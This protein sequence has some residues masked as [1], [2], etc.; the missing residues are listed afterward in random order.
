MAVQQ[1]NVI[2]RFISALLPAI[3]GVAIVLAVFEGYLVYQFTHPK[4]TGEEVTP[5]HYEVL[6][7]GSLPWSQ[8]EWSNLDNTKAVG[9]FLRG[10]SGAPAIV[11]N[12]AYGK[13]RSELLNLGVKLREAGY[14]VLLPDLR[15]HGA[16]PVNW[17]S[18]GEYER[19]DLLA[20]IKFL[21]A[22]R[23]NQGHPLVDGDRIGVYG[24]SLGGYIAV[25]AAA[26]EPSI[27][28]V[29]A[30]SIYPESKALTQ[31]LVD[32]LFTAKPPALNGLVNLGMRCYFLGHYGKASVPEALGS[33]QGRKLWLVT[34]GAAGAFEQSTLELFKQAPDPKEMSLLDHSRITRLE[35]QDQDI[36]DDRIVG[37]FRKDLPRDAVGAE[38]G[39]Q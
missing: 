14:H 7:G 4:R 35:G 28:V 15:G 11:L 34:S 6:T 32:D 3:T 21:K 39:N 25:T 38:S 33:F 17:T 9:W 31:S 22:K 30:D 24:V 5:R 26:Q 37:Y 18:L 27:R 29:I 19:D 2:I 20:A 1:R 13:N 23:D 36:Y 8:E 12:H 16:S 10:A